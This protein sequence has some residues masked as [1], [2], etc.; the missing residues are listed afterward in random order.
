[1]VYLVETLLGKGYDIKIYDENVSLARLIGANKEYIERVIPHI[2]SLMCTSLEEVVSH[3]E[4]LVIGNRGPSF[5]QVINR[6]FNG[7][8]V[9]DLVRIPTH[10]DNVGEG[11]EGICW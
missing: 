4:V 10:P 9:I 6:S 1:M 7:H 8:H 5:T 11:Y 2:A 3:A